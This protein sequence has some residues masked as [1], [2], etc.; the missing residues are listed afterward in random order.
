MSS[1]IRVG[2]LG[3]GRGEGSLVPGLWAVTAHL[4]FLASSSAYKIVAVCNSTVESA[5]A[6]IDARELG[7]DVK[8]YGTPEDIANDP[9][10]DLIVVCV[11]VAKHYAL[12]KPALLAGKDVFVEWPLGATTAEAEEL[13]QIA[14]TKGV[15]TAVGL[16]AIADPVV[17]KLKELVQNEDIGK[18]LSSTVECSFSGI[19]IGM[20]PAGAEWYLDINSG[21]NSFT[22]YFGHCKSSCPI[23]RRNN[24]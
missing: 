13:S 5:Q 17:A 11:Q 2:I 4:P 7:Q 18:I 14:K 6:S 22:I 23:D 3:L 8:A 1:P 20:F 12:A 10:V 9:N 24:Y 19:P 16:Q 15:K 21:G